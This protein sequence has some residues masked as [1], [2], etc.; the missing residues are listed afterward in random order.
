MVLIIS[1]KMYAR[2]IYNTNCSISINI[3][4]FRGGEPPL[5]LCYRY[6]T[7]I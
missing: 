1:R 5:A 2:M 7:I 4:P 3:P 6:Y